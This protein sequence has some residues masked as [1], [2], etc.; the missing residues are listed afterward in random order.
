MT[1]MFSRHCCILAA[2]LL[3]MVLPGT[4]RSDDWPQFQG[5]WRTA[6]S[7]EAGLVS[8]FPS[9]SGPEVLW[10]VELHEGFGG[11]AVAGG[12]VFVMDREPGEA[13]ILLCLDLE[14]GRE[15]WRHVDRVPGRLS[16]SGSRNTPTVEGDYVF[17][18]GGFG[19]V[20]CLQRRSGEP[21]WRFS[22]MDE[23][24]VERPPNWGYAQSPLLVGELLVAC[25]LSEEV[26]LVALDKRTGKVAWKTGPLGSTMS[27]PACYEIKGVEQILLLS[28][29][30]RNAKQGVLAGVSVGD[31]RLLWQSD[32]YFNKFPIPVPVLVGEDSLLLTGG[33]EAG[34]VLLRLE[35]PGDAIKVRERYRIAG[36]SQVHAP[37][38]V[39]DYLYILLN[40]N[41]NYKTRTQREE[42]GGLACLR[43]AD[44]QEVWRTGNAPYFGRG[45]MIRADG[46]LIIQDGHNGVLRLVEPSP[47]GYRQ[48]GE[49]N[50]FGIE[51]LDQDHK[52]WSPL[53]LSDGRLVM[54][55]QQRLICVDL[56]RKT[57]GP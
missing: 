12:E 15:R 18:I 17:I 54:R 28:T 27:Q 11:A 29:I 44:G 37:Q 35:G 25:V 46:K 53:A 41:A 4:A 7:G 49:A 55:G 13:D 20:S 47:S 36:G 1:G 19:Q 43:V 52:F 32:A 33:Y 10:R 45:S 23:F 38:V 51:D 6:V 8:S 26:G 39:G 14:T 48:L 34:S 40:E 16:F 22:I 56:R 5:P 31:G 30:D 3:G 24:S 50:V 57:A 2:I 9:G 21:V 42:G